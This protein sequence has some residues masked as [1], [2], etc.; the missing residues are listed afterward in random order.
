MRTGRQ[1]VVS[2]ALPAIAVLLTSCSGS[3]APGSPTPTTSPTASPTPAPAVALARL[4]RNGVH[5]SYTASYA[6]RTPKTHGTELVRRTPARYRV[7]LDIGRTRSTLI[8]TQA[9]YVACAGRGSRATCGR[10][11]SVPAALNV[12]QLFTTYLV[13]LSKTGYPVTVD[14]STSAHGS[15]PAGTCFRVGGRPHTKAALVFP[16]TYCFSSNGVPTKATFASRSLTLQG[17]HMGRPTKDAFRP[18]VR[19]T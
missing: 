4:A 15:V 9:G 2:V 1:R 12:A 8:H 19:P 6:L 18:P 17:L 5:A 7:D 11:A 10:L 3:S 16:G 14:G 13:E